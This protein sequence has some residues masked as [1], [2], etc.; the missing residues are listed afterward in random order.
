LLEDDVELVEHML[1][2]IVHQLDNI[3]LN[4]FTRG[5]HWTCCV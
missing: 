4:P 5:Q 3:Y 2:A 1:T